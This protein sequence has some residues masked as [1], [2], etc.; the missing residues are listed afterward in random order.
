[1]TVLHII[2]PFA[3]GV[4]TFLV[5]L[6]RELDEHNHIV[7]HGRRTTMDRVDLVRKRFADGVEFVVWDHAQREIGLVADFRAFLFLWRYLRRHPVD[8]VHLHSSKAGFLGRLACFMLGIRTVIYTPHAAAF[9][10][11]DIHVL[12][13]KLY[14]WLEKFSNLLCGTIVSCCRSEM[15]AYESVGVKT[16][17]INNGTTPMNMVKRRGERLLVI[18]SAFM[19]PQKN[20]ALFNTIAMHFAGNPAIEFC[21]V[22]DGELRGQIHAPNVRVT[23]WLTAEETRDFFER[24]SI[25]LA[26]SQWEGLPYS[27]L[28]AMNASCALLLTNCDGHRDVVEHGRNGYLFSTADEAVTCLH[29]FLEE[30]ELIPAMGEVSARL[31]RTNFNA[32]S[33][34]ASYNTLYLNLQ[35]ERLNKVILQ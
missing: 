18:C 19:N 22:G 31:I 29:R 17:C 30:P 9:L 26:T 16:L 5:H 24:A 32:S 12:T 13:R 4:V 3:G 28:E 15:L 23:G 10:R 25:Y 34:A 1:M 35:H 33:M 6:T 27:V 20:P 7:L 8:V 11:K 14:V 21:W 2:E